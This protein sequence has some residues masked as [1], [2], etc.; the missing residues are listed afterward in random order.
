MAR[1]SWQSFQEGEKRGL[2]PY[3]QVWTHRP[4]GIL[5]TLMARFHQRSSFYDAIQVRRK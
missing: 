1:Q 5:L 3:N 2:K 4:R